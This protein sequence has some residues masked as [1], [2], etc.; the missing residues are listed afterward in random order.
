MKKMNFG[1][2]CTKPERIKMSRT[3]EKIEKLTLPV[4]AL[5]GLVAFPMMPLTFELQRDISIKACRA[6]M[7][8]DMYIFLTAQRDIS[9]EKPSAEDLYRNGCIARIKQAVSSHDGTMRVST[10]GLLR[11]C[12]STLLESDGY[13][14]AD[15]I[16]RSVT[17]DHDNSLR[18]EALTSEALKV[19]E[20]MLS[21]VPSASSDIMRTARAIKSPGALADFLASSTL[22]R[23]Q[24]K[25]KIL[26]CTDPMKRLELLIVTAES[27]MELV[28]T[29]AMIHSR[30]KEQIDENQREYY[31]REQLKVIQGELGID[32]GDD[33]AE[34]SERISRA[35][36][37]DNVREKLER[38][39]VR[40]TKA[41]FAS[42]EAAVSR[43]YLET[44]LDIP[45]G[46]RSEGSTD[47]ENAS[48]I[49]ERDHDGLCDVKERIL[50][51]LAVKCMKEDMRGQVI[52]FVG[53]PG[54]GKTSLG[55]SVAEA[56]GR[57]YV[58]VSL[59]GVR[60]ES[61][62]RGHRKTYI[63]SMPGRIISALIE[64]GTMNPMIQLD[65]IDKVCRDAHGDPA[66]ALLEVLDFEQNSEFRD[67]YVELPVDLSDCIFLASANT[68]S[69]IPTPLIDRMDIIELH[70]YTPREKFSIASNHL[71]PKQLNKHGLKARQV[72]ITDEALTELISGYTRESGVREL[73]RKIAALC[74]KSIKHMLTEGSKSV[75]VSPNK[76]KVFLGPRKYLDEEIQ[77]EGSVGVA[78]GL[79]Y[80]EVGGDILKI[81]ASV[82]EGSGKLELTGK[83][84]DVMKESAKIAFSYVRAHC[85]KYGIDPDFYKKYD[86]HIHVPEGAVPKDGPSAGVT[87]TSVLIS[88]LGGIKL[89]GDTAMTGEVTLTGRVLPIGGLREKSTAAYTA[90]ISRVIIP[91]GNEPDLEQLETEVRKAVRFIP[92]RDLSEV[93]AAA[94][95][96]DEQTCES[97]V[98]KTSAIPVGGT[99]RI[100]ADSE[101]SDT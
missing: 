26:E 93:L 96:H 100:R 62:I 85:K 24:D 2:I 97:C 94:L 92:C 70:T 31:L 69:T 77:T 37:P 45:W 88:A 32:G 76:L 46:I 29:E 64:A 86:I 6:A 98:A 80:T 23:Y 53:P 1:I 67:H 42:P 10:E 65:E 95:C 35:V 20:N 49:L 50:E 60:D 43:T 36:L 83:L 79:A 8:N 58:R 44:C 72:K 59:G 12:I 15:I 30:V 5:R 41:P 16:S 74:R 61:D 40:F 71:I 99:L 27:E 47:L 63:G 25:Q 82:M 55:R 56:L 52:C 81:E 17:S 34:L 48:A 84:G 73:D 57:K 19:A 101:H 89:R 91:Q 78:C 75:T 22:I 66:S 7:E 3:I 90:G 38:E 54:V 9:V 4:I 51:Y 33:A 18:S 13:F 11:G 14:S 21:Y 28:R 68:L 87:L 39:L